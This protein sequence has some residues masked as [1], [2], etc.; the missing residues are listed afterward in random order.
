MTLKAKNERVLDN[1]KKED[2]KADLNLGE[3][4]PAIIDDALTSSINIKLEETKEQQTSLQQ[5]GEFGED[6]YYYRSHNFKRSGI[7]KIEYLDTEPDI[8]DPNFYCKS[9][10]SVYTNAHAYRRHLQHVHY[11][12]LKPIP[13]RKTSKNDH[14]PDHDNPSLHC[15][16]CNHT[17]KHEKTYKAHCHYGHGIKSVESENG[18]PSSSGIMDSYCQNCDKRLASIK[19]YRYHLI[20]IHKVD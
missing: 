11:M 12:D 1:I 20:S 17:Y 3:A 2:D 6:G 15:R 16:A 9:C 14:V 8:H 10:E 5:K 7:K 13:K 4:S 19:S 18:K